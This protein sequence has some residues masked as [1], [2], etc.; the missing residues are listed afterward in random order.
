M[1]IISWPVAATAE[2]KLNMVPSNTVHIKSAS[3]VDNVLAAAES[4][5]SLAPK[6]KT[7][8]N[9]DDVEE[10]ALEQAVHKADTTFCKAWC[11][12]FNNAMSVKQP[13]SFS[14]KKAARLGARRPSYEK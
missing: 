2:T 10:V 14:D 4:E 5:T 3:N 1:R 12:Y 11:L 9:K 8:C 7:P 13:N 6:P